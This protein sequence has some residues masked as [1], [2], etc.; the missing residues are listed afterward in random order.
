M[1]HLHPE[2]SG[3]AILSF[4]PRLAQFRRHAS[5]KCSKCCPPYGLPLDAPAL[6]G[7]VLDRAEDDALAQQPDENHGDEPVEHRGYFRLVAVL[8]DDPAEPAAARG[9]AEHQVLPALRTTAGCPSAS[10]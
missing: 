7:R 10:P 9:D 4:R 5:G 6:D 3:H 1:V 8:E 2:P